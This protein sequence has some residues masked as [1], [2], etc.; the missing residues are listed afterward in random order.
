MVLQ[1]KLSDVGRLTV[2]CSRMSGSHSAGRC[3]RQNKVSSLKH[4]PCLQTYLNLVFYYTVFISCPLLYFKS[5]N[6]TLHQCYTKQVTLTATLFYTRVPS[7]PAN[8][9]FLLNS[10]LNIII[11]S[12]PRSQNLSHYFRFPY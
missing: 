12:M 7:E 4:K 11:Q 8:K 1:R 5:S 10:Y 2:V 9:N 6:E 3:H